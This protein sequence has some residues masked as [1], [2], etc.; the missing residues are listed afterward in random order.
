[1]SSAKTR[2]AR[3][4]EAYN[5]MTRIVL[6]AFLFLVSVTAV[7]AFVWARSYFSTGQ[8]AN[9]SR[10][11]PVASAQQ[12]DPNDD[13]TIP[14]P[15]G[16]LQKET[17]PTPIPWDGKSRVTILVMGLDEREAEEDDIPRTDTLI[18]LS[19]DPVSKTAGMISIPRDLW[20]NIPDIGYNKINT[21][22]RWGEVYELP[23][24]GPGVAMK[25]VEQMLG[26]PVHFYAQIDFMAFVRL[27]DELGGL[28][29]H[30]REEIIVDPIGPGNTKTL[31]PGVQPLDGATVL[32]YARMRYTEGGD[33]DRAGR[34][35][36]VIMALREQVLRL[37]QLPTL[38]LKA[39][40]LYQQLSSG[41]RTNLNL[42]QIIQ[43][44]RTAAQIDE[45]QIRRG[46]I[47]PPLQ[48]ELATN[49]SDGQSILIPVQDQIVL[50]RDEV[51]TSQRSTAPPPTRTPPVIKVPTA[52]PTPS[53]DPLELMEAEQT[54]VLI[55]NGTMTTGLASKTGELLRSKG[56]SVIG[57]DNA[58]ELSDHTVIYDYTGKP[59][60]VMYLAELLNVSTSRIFNRFDPNAEVDVEIIL[61]EDWAST[62]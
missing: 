15:S 7:L 38:I 10:T 49:P 36:E 46:V 2:M 9:R 62:Q 54:R 33:F 19:L 21:A 18:L 60:T 47:S 42:Q 8:S 53:G 1:M 30:I 29:M 23:G 31:E 3:R 20:V 50:L 61:G 14:T 37:N 52:T 13:A 17:G 48:V 41:L 45:H 25:T 26:T 24:G 5:R 44:A 16:P 27:I 22:Y 58:D 28:T 57:E 11:Q 4:R 40:R 12:N 43:L 51:F 35:Q 55:L 39:P 59:Y 6:A 32:A 56:I 34:Q